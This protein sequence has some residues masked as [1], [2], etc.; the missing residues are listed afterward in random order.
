MKILLGCG[1]LLLLAAAALGMIIVLTFVQDRNAA[2]YP[3]STSISRHDNY[4]GLPTQ[5]R[6]DNSYQTDDNFT[7]VYNWY[8][9]GF[10]LGS[11]ARAL[12][13]C[14]LLEGSKK[15]TVIRRYMSVMLCDT[16]RGRLIYVT[17]FTSLD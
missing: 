11:E 7:R 10:D 8:S 15:W 12:G 17:R 13:G 9:I 14:I 5:F 1:G 16:P 3:E 4:T 2:R 6:W